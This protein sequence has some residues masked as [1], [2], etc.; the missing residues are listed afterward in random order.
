M[1][2]IYLS[3]LFVFTFSF[4]LFAQESTG[5]TDNAPNA[6][7]ENT[8]TEDAPADNDQASMESAP[9]ELENPAEEPADETALSGDPSSATTKSADT[10]QVTQPEA[11]DK[12]DSEPEPKTDSPAI[13]DDSSA[14]NTEPTAKPE[15]PFQPLVNPAPAP[16]AES[17]EES[18]CPDEIPCVSRNGLSVWPKL[19]LRAGYAYQQ[20]DPDVLFVGQNDG[21]TLEQVRFGFGGS[22]KDRFFIRTVIDAVSLIPGQGENNPIQ[23]LVVSVV[24]AYLHYAPS[25]F[26][27]V[28]AG[29]TF[30]P[31]DKEGSTS[32]AALIFANRSVAA[33]GVRP[34]YGFE[35]G[36]LS[37]ARQLGLV[38]GANDA[39]V[40]PVSLDYRAAI[41]NG[42]GPSMFGN[43]NKLP[44][45]YGRFG[46]GFKD[47][48][49][50][51]VGGSY[52]P[53]T[54]GNVPSL[55]DE[56]DTTV[57]GDLSI[58]AFGFELLAQGIARQTTFDS[59]F[60]EVTDPNRSAL[61]FGFTTFVVIDKPFGFSTFGFK[62]GYRF[63]YYDPSSSFYDDQLIEQSFA[64]RYDPE[65][66]Q[67]PI[68]LV[69]DFTSVIE[70]NES[71]LRQMDNN[72]ATAL[73]QFDL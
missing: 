44:A 51:A 59:V 71:G 26:L 14:L 23:P 18:F 67:L 41:S 57:F 35:V 45:G 56:L 60:P 16:S 6:Q 7:T 43:D 12:S 53:R 61:A 55:Y 40:G 68:A 42:N 72:R 30:M 33:G 29:Q 13:I 27:Q 20:P 9:D 8:Q 32:R 49:R 36:G 47:Y 21:F 5:Q 65:T 4:S 28:W 70:M 24:D 58:D 66:Y 10:T 19:R 1:K 69:F 22:Y 34:G 11:S 17:P 38:V 39:R 73:V 37:P 25:P 3:S 48:A 52:N 50:I 46:I 54:V 63:S 62:P 15:P 2:K 64:L 31:A